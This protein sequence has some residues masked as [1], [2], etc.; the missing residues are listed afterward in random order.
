MSRAGR[1]L[2]WAGIVVGTVGAIFLI[3]AAVVVRRS[4]TPLERRLAAIRAVGEPLTLAELAPDPI[5]PEHNAAIYLLRAAADMDAISSQLGDVFGTR[6]AELTDADLARIRDAFA[7]FPE[8]VPLLTQAG[9]APDYQPPYDYSQDILAF[10]NDLLS[11]HGLWRNRFRVLDTYVSL[12]L[13][14]GREAEA[15]QAALTMLRLSRHVAREPTVVSYL[16]AG[17]LRGMATAN[18]SRVLRTAPLPAESRRLLDAE[19]AAID[20]A[21]EQRHALRTGRAEVVEFYRHLPPQRRWP[22]SRDE[23]P[24]DQLRYL[25][26]IEAALATVDQPGPHAAAVAKEREKLDPLIEARR[27]SA[28]LDDRVIRLA[29]IAE[30]AL[31]GLPCVAARSRAETRCLRVLNAVQ[32]YEEEHPGA[33]PELADLALPAE[34]IS[35]PYTGEPLRMKRLPEGWLVYS[36]GKNLTDNGGD[37]T[38]APGK[39]ALDVGFGP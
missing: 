33:V 14:E 13:A 22:F 23:T 28:V 15:L 25:D 32:A 4:E 8:V 17:A 37:V 38:A 6:Q 16:S 26:L 5:P 20:E 27:M 19:L 3:A 2:K 10:Q 35:D 24:I 39:L 30:P 7:A 29:E 21:A 11:G 12:C 36:V 34:A 1:L 18:A 31:H 9:E